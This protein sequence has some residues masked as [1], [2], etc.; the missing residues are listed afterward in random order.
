MSVKLYDQTKEPLI[1]PSHV[2]ISLH[3]FMVQHHSV[4]SGTILEPNQA[5]GERKVHYA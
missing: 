3:A 4:K 5:S 2:I 1:E